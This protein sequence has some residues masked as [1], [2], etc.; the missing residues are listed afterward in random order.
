MGCSLVIS[1]SVQWRQLTLVLTPGR[2]KAW[3]L[4]VLMS[5]QLCRLISAYLHPPTPPFVYTAY[6]QIIAFVNPFT[7]IVSCE[8]DP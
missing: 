2:D 4:L 7:A 6:I 3:D 1:H 5:Q 8:N